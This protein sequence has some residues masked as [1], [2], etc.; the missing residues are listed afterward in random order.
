MFSS[1]PQN[2]SSYT[3]SYPFKPSTVKGENSLVRKDCEQPFAATENQIPCL[4]HNKTPPPHTTRKQ[5][6]GAFCFEN[7]IPF[8]PHNKKNRAQ[9]AF[10]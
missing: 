7:Q 9:E 2:S 8:P 10:N 1:K 3:F 5:R 4:P 6:R